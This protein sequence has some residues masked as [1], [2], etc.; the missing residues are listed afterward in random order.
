MR[1]PTLST[2]F[3]G[4]ALETATFLLNRTPTKAIE[5]TSYEIWTGHRPN[6]SFL[7]IWGCESHV[8]KLTSDKRASKTDKCLFVGY[9]RETIG[10]YF[11]NPNENKVFVAQKAV[12]LEKK[13]IFK[14][15]SGSKVERQEVQ[16]PQTSI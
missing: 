15:N 1:N 4:F 8:K 16:E 14:K 6:M 11:Y 3:W 2:S 9:P 12:F 13:F 5:K 7:R 10:Y